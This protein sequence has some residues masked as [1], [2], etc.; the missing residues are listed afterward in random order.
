MNKDTV[1]PLVDRGSIWLPGNYLIDFG[2]LAS[3]GGDIYKCICEPHEPEPG[4]PELHE[5]EPDK[6]HT[7]Y[8][9]GEPEPHEP[10]PVTNRT[11][12][13][14]SRQRMDANVTEP[15]AS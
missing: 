5:P 13:N 7:G 10:E 8:E 2:F 12:A 15:W 11:A 9:P 4:E 6:S 1:G 3:S 14:R